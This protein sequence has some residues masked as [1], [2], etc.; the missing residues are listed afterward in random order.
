MPDNVTFEDRPGYRRWRRWCLVGVALPLAALTIS[1]RSGLAQGNPA[2]LLRQLQGRIASLT[3]T[4]QRQQQQISAMSQMRSTEQQQMQQLQ[5][6]VNAAAAAGDPLAQAIRSPNAQIMQ[7]KLIAQLQA[8]VHTPQGSGSAGSADTF[9][10]DLS[11]ARLAGAVLPGSKLA[12]V[13]LKGADLSR[14]DLTHAVLAGADLQGAKLQGAN[15]TAADLANVNLTG[16]L[17]DSQTRW[18]QG[19]VP[20][21]HGALD[22]K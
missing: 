18:P 21:Q 8:R 17:Y 19:F 4:V 5:R 14:A 15:L 3:T 2:F 11:G 20:A 9:V 22:V 6:A 7:G 13:N 1:P 16:A 12:K 10:A